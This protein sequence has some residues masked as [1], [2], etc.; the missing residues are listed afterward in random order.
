MWLWLPFPLRQSK[1]QE[2]ALLHSAL[3]YA[4]KHYLVYKNLYLLFKKLY[5]SGHTFS[6]RYHIF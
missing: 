1:A 5:K 4:L 6:F 2:T 3:F